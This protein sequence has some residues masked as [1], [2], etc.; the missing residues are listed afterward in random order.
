[1]VMENMENVVNEIEKHFDKAWDEIRITK[2]P[3]YVALYNILHVAEAS[4]NKGLKPQ[5]MIH[6]RQALEI[7]IPHVY[8]RCDNGSNQINLEMYSS[9]TNG[10]LA[11]VTAEAIL[12]AQFYEWFS[13]HITDYHGNMQCQVNGRSITFSDYSPKRT[14]R[15]GLMHHDLRIYHEAHGLSLDKLSN[16]KSELPPESFGNT[17]VVH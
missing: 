11:I 1:M 6:I 12:F 16:I 13:Y 15:R 8:N 17:A 3:L 10:E 14:I 7:L 5:Q 2:S 9:V 4:F